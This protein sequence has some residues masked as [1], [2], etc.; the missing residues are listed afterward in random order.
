MLRDEHIRGSHQQG[1]AIGRGARHGFG[2]DHPAG[3]RAVLYQYRVPL[4]SADLFAQQTGQRVNDA[5]R[6]HWN[7][8]LDRSRLLRPRA[9]AG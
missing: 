6:R 9:V 5:A 3:P 7:D 2:C 8:N 4:R 1:V